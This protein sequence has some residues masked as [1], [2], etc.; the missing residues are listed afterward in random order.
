M[1]DNVKEGLQ[2][3][4][5]KTFELTE[6]EVRPISCCV[7]ICAHFCN[8]VNLRCTRCANNFKNMI[9]QYRLLYGADSC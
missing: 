4:L 6:D 9:A 2:R 7:E 3:N 5:S 1:T 8:I